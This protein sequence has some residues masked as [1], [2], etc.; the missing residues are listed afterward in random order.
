[1]HEAG[2]A[3]AIAAALHDAPERHDAAHLRLI[4]KGGH[5]DPASFDAALRFHLGFHAPELEMD[6]LQV[7][8]EPIVRL[9]SGCGQPFLHADPF[10]P[11][12]RCAAPAL[13]T[14][15]PEEVEF[16]WIDDVPIGSR[17]A[18]AAA[19]NHVPVLW[20]GERVERG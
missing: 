7:V 14:G 12:P 20:D 17:S 18:P 1:M 3:I 11:C 6:R 8:H 5:D 10:G 2:L 15:T 16:E 4:I 19:A 13:R 9:C